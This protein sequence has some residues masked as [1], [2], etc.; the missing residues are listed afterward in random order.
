MT[1]KEIEDKLQDIYMENY[2]AT[3]QSVKKCMYEAFNFALEVAA[4]KAN[5][6]L[7]ENRAF[8]HLVDKQSILNLKVK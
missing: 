3:P 8:I 6:V 7:T 2:G 1:Q 5:I 4:E